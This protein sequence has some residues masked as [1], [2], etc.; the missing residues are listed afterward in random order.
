MFIFIR[1]V[2]QWEDDMHKYQQPIP[3]TDE[4]AA[5]WWQVMDRV[6]YQI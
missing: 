6:Y 4:K 1:A 3:G 5:V 2:Q